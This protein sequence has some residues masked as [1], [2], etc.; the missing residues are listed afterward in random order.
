[1]GGVVLFQILPNVLQLA[2]GLV[3]PICLAISHDVAG[4]RTRGSS[5]YIGQRQVGLGRRDSEAVENLVEPA[6][7][8]LKGKVAEVLSL[9]VGEFSVVPV[10]CVVAQAQVDVAL[11]GLHRVEDKEAAEVVNKSISGVKNGYSAPL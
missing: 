3:D 6:I 5:R 4:S 2:V 10:K 9:G 1:M 8:M 7:F 11:D